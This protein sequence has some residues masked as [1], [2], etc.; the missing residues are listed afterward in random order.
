MGII[1]WVLA[2]QV[3]C[4]ALGAALLDFAFAM[5]PG[6]EANGIVHAIYLFLKG[7]KDAA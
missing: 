4:S 7:K 5:A 3:V 2:H 6:I 1:N